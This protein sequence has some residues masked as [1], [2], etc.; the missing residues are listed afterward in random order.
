LL[1]IAVDG[2]TPENVDDWQFHEFHNVQCEVNH[3]MANFQARVNTTAKTI[4]VSK[5]EDVDWAD[6]SDVVLDTLGLPIS[7]YSSDESMTFGS[8]LG[9]TVVL[10]LIQL[11]NI[12]GNNS[13]ETLFES[14]EDFLASLV[15]NS[16]GMLSATRLVGANAT[17]PVDASVGL[18][19]V[20]YSKPIYIYGI[21]ALN[22]LL[23][24]VFIEEALRTRLWHG[25][26]DLELSDAAM[27]I[28]TGSAGGTAVAERTRNLSKKQI[29]DISV[30]V[31]TVKVDKSRRCER[32]CA[33]LTTKVAPLLLMSKKDSRWCSRGL[34]RCHSLQLSAAFHEP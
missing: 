33:T 34:G 5:L 12:N 28:V 15:D 19:A 23:I 20:I 21:L 3:K 2:D 1:S 7:R 32:S 25:M 6:Y 4:Q 31:S 24:F 17:V 16:L 18:P 13:T 22:I 8:Q 26:V 14:L 11:Q 10:N 30:R 27:V 29:G 9:H